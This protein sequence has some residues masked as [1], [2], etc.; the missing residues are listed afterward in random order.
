MFN[1]GLVK[2]EVMCKEQLEGLSHVQYV[3]KISN[4]TVSRTTNRT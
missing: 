4:L 3:T 2:M 1:L